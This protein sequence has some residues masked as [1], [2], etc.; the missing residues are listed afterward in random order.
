MDYSPAVDTASLPDNLNHM[1]FVDEQTV[2]IMPHLETQET[3]T[4]TSPTGHEHTAEIPRQYMD[5][6]RH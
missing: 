2:D 1:L 4:Q 3:P 6:D 5:D